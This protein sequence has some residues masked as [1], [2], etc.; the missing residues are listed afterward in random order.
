MGILSKILAALLGLSLIFGGWNWWRKNVYYDALH[1]VA[2]QKVAAAREAEQK[3]AD[4]RDTQT[5]ELL[6][7]SIARELTLQKQLDEIART[8]PAERVVYK[9]RDRWLPVSCPAATPGAAPGPEVGGLRS[10]DELFLVRFAKSADD[11]ID[12]RNSC[13]ALYDAA[14]QAAID[15]NK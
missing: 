3:L 5:L 12:E 14:R 2:A 4:K 15:A 1:T 10:E 8:P 13:K 11:A 7:R 6:N 9:L